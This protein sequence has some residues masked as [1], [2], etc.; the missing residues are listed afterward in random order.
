MDG[1]PDLTLSQFSAGGGHGGISNVYLYNNGSFEEI[2]M[3]DDFI[4]TY[5]QLATDSQGN[6]FISNGKPEPYNAF[7]DFYTPSVFGKV[8]IKNG[9][10]DIEVIYDENV[11][12]SEGLY[13][14]EDYIKVINENYQFVELSDY[15]I[16]NFRFIT[17]DNGEA[18]FVLTSSEEEIKDTVIDYFGGDYEF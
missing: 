18:A 9:K 3:D 7:N 17:D 14:P 11:G 1:Y 5:L 6:Q 16:I 8:I 2:M 15:S 13:P 4:S 12:E 10:L